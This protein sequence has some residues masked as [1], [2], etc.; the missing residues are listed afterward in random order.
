MWLLRL[1]ETIYSWT[2]IQKQNGKKMF[3]NIWKYQE[4]HHWCMILNILFF[5]NANRFYRNNFGLFSNVFDVFMYCIEKEWFC[6]GW[7]MNFY[8]IKHHMIMLNTKF[9]KFTRSDRW[10]LNLDNYILCL[11][12]TSMIQTITMLL[13]LSDCS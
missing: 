8:W 1:Y 2:K 6:A 11:R 3:G 13:I 4:I 12:W 5:F 10:Y 9:F 7:K